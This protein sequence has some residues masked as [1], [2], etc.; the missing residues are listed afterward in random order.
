MTHTHNE[1]WLKQFTPEQLA[2]IYGFPLWSVLAWGLGMW[3]GFLGSVLLLLRRGCAVN[4]FAVSLVGIVITDL[5]SYGLSD[6]MKVMKGGT[7][8]VVFS[9]V[10]FGIGALLFVYARAMRWR[11][12]LR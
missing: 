5:Y 1:V 9:A 12:V 10:I 2:Y 3:G 4:L 8:A 7:G 11:G 6:W